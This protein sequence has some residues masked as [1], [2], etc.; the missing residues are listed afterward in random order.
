MAVSAAGDTTMLEEVRAMR[1]EIRE[2]RA[3][4]R[5]L[6]RRRPPRLAPPP[7]EV[8]AAPEVRG[9]VVA[10]MQ[11]AEQKRAKR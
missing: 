3:L 8:E 1:A 9:K 6:L 2:L 5:E 11:R 4:V 10:A 7:A